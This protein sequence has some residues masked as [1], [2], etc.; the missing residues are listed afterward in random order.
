MRD[1]LNLLHRFVEKLVKGSGILG[2]FLFLIVMGITTYE[3]LV[4]YLLNA[5]TT[6]SLEISVILTMWATFL[7]IAYTLQQGGHTQVD[8]VVSRLSERSRRV[9][10]IFVYL[11]V[12]LF[13]IFLTW[14]SLV[15]AIEAYLI[16]EVTQSYTRTPLVILMISVPIGGFLLILEIVRELTGMF[17]LRKNGS[18]DFP[19]LRKEI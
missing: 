16:K 7:G 3:V 15:P 10:R 19:G 14:A 17:R 8:L 18:P 6:W 1:R 12:L 2:A 13:S 4:R 11:F 9:L 5:P